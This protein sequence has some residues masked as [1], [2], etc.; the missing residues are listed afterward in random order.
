MA[1]EVDPACLDLPGVDPEQARDLARWRHAERLRLRNKR[2]ALAVADRQAAGAAIFGHLSDLLRQRF[3]TL[4]G[5]LFSGSWP[6]KGAP[7]LRLLMAALHAEGALT[8]LPLAALSP[9]PFTIGTGFQTARL[10][11]IYPQP[12]DIAPDASVTEPGSAGPPHG[13]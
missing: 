2:E 5:R 13:A 8:A 9:R 11:A 10:A 7:D 6:I 1:T 3:G 4:R 12:H